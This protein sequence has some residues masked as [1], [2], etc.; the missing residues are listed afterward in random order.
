V[1]RFKI[2]AKS[3]SEAIMA[4]KKAIKDLALQDN[5][6]ARNMADSYFCNYD[7]GNV[8]ALGG[9][10]YFDNRKLARNLG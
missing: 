4:G 9:A 8:L 7:H 5:I 2:S 1:L 10:G 6:I 3:E